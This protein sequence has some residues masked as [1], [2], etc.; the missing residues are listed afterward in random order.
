MYSDAEVHFLKIDSSSNLYDSARGYV[1]KID[2]IRKSK[3][4]PSNSNQPNIRIHRGEWYE[5][6]TLHRAKIRE[7]KNSDASNKLATCADYAAKVDNTVGMIVLKNRATEL[8]KCI[9]EAT[10]DFDSTD[11]MKVSEV[12]ALCVIMLGYK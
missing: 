12:A 10:R 9:D 2:S 1:K 8:M 3:K 11:D 7:W 5:G 4:T 6:G